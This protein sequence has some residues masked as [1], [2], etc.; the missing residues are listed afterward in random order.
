MSED[1]QPVKLIIQPASVSSSTDTS[2]HRQAYDPRQVTSGGVSDIIEHYRLFDYLNISN[3]ER[4]KDKIN[5]RVKLVHAW[6]KDKAK[7][8][9]DYDLFGALKHLEMRLG[10]PPLGQ[11]MLNHLYNFISLDRQVKDLTLQRDIMIRGHGL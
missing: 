9:N 5:D 10:I 1:I 6:A 8:D 2:E 3:E 7:T 11:S 4:Q